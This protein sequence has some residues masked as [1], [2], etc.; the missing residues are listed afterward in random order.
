MPDD[1]VY[2][3]DK[4][5]ADIEVFLREKETKKPIPV[6]GLLGGTKANPRPI[7]GGEGFAVQEDN[8]MAEFNI[9]PAQSGKDFSNNIGYVLAYLTGFFANKGL[10]INI[11]GSEVFQPEQLGNP[12]AR[13]FGCDPDFCAWTMEEN[14]IDSFNP[15][16]RTLRTAGGH[17]HVGF[18]RIDGKALTLEEIILLVKLLD[19]HLSV[20]SVFVDKDLRR[21]EFYGKAGAFRLKPYGVEYRTMSNFWCE[22]DFYR[23]WVYEAVRTCIKQLSWGNHWEKKFEQ[24]RDLILSAIN[25]NDERAASRI[26]RIFGIWIPTKDKSLLKSISQI[27]SDSID[28]ESEENVP[29]TAAE[30]EDM[31]D[32]YDD[33]PQEENAA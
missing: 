1:I 26:V 4:V 23:G 22:N 31:I 17:V 21:K 12:Q 6:V 10:E 14:E 28:N 7:D 29:L 11:Q 8:V 33:S 13:T 20:P 18:N 9:P 30:L 19:L 16:L 32:T 24:H 27:A 5:G 3:L 15:K 2:R 25:N